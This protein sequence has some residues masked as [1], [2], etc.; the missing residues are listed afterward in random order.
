MVT[1]AVA[2]RQPAVR[3]ATTVAPPA[4][5]GVPHWGLPEWFIIGQTA[6]PALLYLPG[7]Q[8][9][10][11][12]IR[13]ASF[14]ISLLGLLV[15]LHSKRRRG[16]HF[17]PAHLWLAAAVVYLGLMLLHPTTNSFIAGA[18]QITLYLA[19]LAPVFW[20]AP[21]VRGP[22]HLARLLVLLFLCSGVN[23]LVG[24]LQV[25]DP[26]H[27]MPQEFSRVVTGSAYGLEAVSYLGPD[28]RR[29]IRP[30]GLF[31]AP[32][33][34]CAPGMVAVLLGLMF[35]LNAG[36]VWKKIV[37]VLFT[38]LGMAAIFLSHVRSSFV[39][40]A[41]MVVVGTFVLLI[42]QK[43]RL[44]AAVLLGLSGLLLL[45]AF[46][47]AVAL[48]GQSTRERFASLLEQNLLEL[49]HTTRGG[50]L[51]YGFSTLLV[52]YP[53]GAGLGRWGMINV[54]FGDA[55]NRQASPIWAELQP[56]AW[57][58]DGGFVLLLLYGGA[59]WL[60]TRDGLRLARTGAARDLRWWAVAVFVINAGTLALM[61]SFTPF[62]TQVGLQYWFLSGALQG[63]A[64][65]RGGGA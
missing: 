47:V 13:V 16:I 27:W 65:K 44:K 39:V 40:V 36:A 63:A 12:P 45:G 17:R 61:L 5:A 49:Y 2:E 48:G 11:L 4:A 31:D 21:L 55:S 58:V 33:A 53:L 52:D 42:V 56:N 43:E 35:C 32:G 8:P 22:R 18:A 15:W 37:A 29:I 19:V 9:S 28:G 62:T 59:L 24:I 34:V 10:R 60:N 50:Q 14:A 25:Y 41:G 7:S 57:I 51:E 64:L 38:L 20:V 26:A 23:C 30:P 54:Y 46:S 1:S 6:I 3:A